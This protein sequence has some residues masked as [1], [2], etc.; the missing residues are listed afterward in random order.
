MGC[1]Q[2]GCVLAH[3]VTNKVVGSELVCCCIS[4]GAEEV[5]GQAVQV[6]ERRA[7]IL[8]LSGGFS[9]VEL[10]GELWEFP[11]DG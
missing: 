8:Q 9:P 6:G 10:R 3:R 1:A 5:G 7:A 11:G 2:A 4:N